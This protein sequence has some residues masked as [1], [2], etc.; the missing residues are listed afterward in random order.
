MTIKG[1]LGMVSSQFCRIAYRPVQ[2]PLIRKT[3]QV[4]HR[5]AHASQSK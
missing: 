3:A 1:E 4:V 5:A 2:H